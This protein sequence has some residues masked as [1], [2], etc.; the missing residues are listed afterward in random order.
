[1]A[2]EQA[3]KETTGTSTV[4][5]LREMLTEE[6]AKPKP[7]FKLIPALFS[8]LQTAMSVA[9]EASIISHGSVAIANHEQQVDFTTTALTVPGVNPRADEHLVALD[10]ITRRSGPD[11]LDAAVRAVPM[12]GD[13]YHND[14]EGQRR[15]L[16]RLRNQLEARLGPE[17]EEEADDH[18]LA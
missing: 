13:I 8:A 9:G 4:D 5:R 2:D 15:F 10:Q 17:E 7:S 1:M 6:I 11:P 18:P 14:T 16:A 12:L 3:D